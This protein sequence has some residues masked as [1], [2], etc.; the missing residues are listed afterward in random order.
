MRG[1]RRF[2]SL[3]AAALAACGGPSGRAADPVAKAVAAADLPR[4]G[5][6]GDVPSPAHSVTVAATADGKLFTSEGATDLDGLRKQLTDAASRAPHEPDGS[7]RLY[8][9]LR[10]HRAAPWAVACWLM[11]ACASPEVKAY[12]TTFAVRA[13]EDDSEGAIVCE[14]PADRDCGRV[15][16]EPH[17]R[18]CASAS[19]APFDAGALYADAVWYFQKH[20]KCYGAR[21]DVPPRA[22]VGAVLAMLDVLRR[23]GA[24]RVW[25]TGVSLPRR[26]PEAPPAPGR[27]LVQDWVAR[28][29]PLDGGWRVALGDYEVRAGEGDPPPPAVMRLRGFLAALPPTHSVEDEWTPADVAGAKKGAGRVG[30]TGSP[31]EEDLPP[32][33]EETEQVHGADVVA[34]EPTIKDAELARANE[35]DRDMPLEPE[36]E[37]PPV[38][39]EKEPVPAANPGVDLPSGLPWR[40]GDRGYAIERALEW[41]AAHQRKDGSW[42]S[43]DEGTTGHDDAVTALAVLALLGAGDRGTSSGRGRDRLVADQA[44]DG[45]IGGTDRLGHATATAALVEAC[46]VRGDEARRP[47]AQR[48]LD[49][50]A[51]WVD[52]IAKRR[53]PLPEDASVE[54]WAAMAFACARLAN[55]EATVRGTPSP[56]A[57]AERTV[58]A[59]VGRLSDLASRASES[60]E[61][62]AGTPSTRLALSGVATFAR[63]LLTEDPR[64]GA[65]EGSIPTFP[66]WESGA[67]ADFAGAFFGGL[68][69]RQAGGASW[70]DFRAAATEATIARQR[71]DGPAS[72]KGGSFDPRDVWGKS[73][74]RAY[75]TAMAALALLADDLF[76]PRFTVR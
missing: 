70:R 69:A 76:S 62:A 13:E 1:F 54:A 28:N 6:V 66:A 64:D 52:E 34:K 61:P 41:L 40:R 18:V 37:L 12:R 45:R 47:S 53:K 43:E 10:V 29:P 49:L 24:R 73:G 74:G 17:L 50:L 72:A 71:T 5:T 16:A 39:E 75:A 56:F 42:G 25:F 67:D 8:A 22:P 15:D 4:I 3:A 59:L 57:V 11:Q 31:V 48:A 26:N 14:L 23:A 63:G 55:H 46:R 36:D 44:K 38:P 20:P 68:V 7:S 30:G 19:T 33:P 9:V 21:L 58:D 2:V 27:T 60:S 65:R 35:T 32:Q 51:T